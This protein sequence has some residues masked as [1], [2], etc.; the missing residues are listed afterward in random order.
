MSIAEIV[1]QMNFVIL[2]DLFINIYLG[3]M[4][5]FL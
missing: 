4:E 3:I 1:L 5:L 2:F